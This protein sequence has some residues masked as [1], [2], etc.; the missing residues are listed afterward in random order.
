MMLLVQAGMARVNGVQLR[1]M[2]LY[3]D[4]FMANLLRLSAIQIHV[5]T[6]Y[7]TLLYFNYIHR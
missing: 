4:A 3:L 2:L 7:F 6:L 1:L 5:Y